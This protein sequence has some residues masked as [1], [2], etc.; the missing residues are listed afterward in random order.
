MGKYTPLTKFLKQL[1]EDSIT[2]TFAQIERIITPDT[3]P[4]NARRK[5][6]SNLFNLRWWDN[7]PGA[8][9]SDARLDAGFQTVMVD[10]ENEKVKLRRIKGV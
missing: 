6:N 2:L 3:L 8:L 9:E 7:S 10:F 5:R 1:P 4:Y